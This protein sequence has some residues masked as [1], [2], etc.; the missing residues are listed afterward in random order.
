MHNRIL[1]AL[2]LLGTI[3]YG[4]TSGEYEKTGSGLNYKF[5][6]EGEGPAPAN[7]DVILLNISYLDENNNILFS[8]DD[9]QQGPMPLS[10]N[11]SVF[12]RTGGIEEGIKMIQE[13]DSLVL[14]FPIEDLYENT[15]NMTLPDSIRRGSNVTVCMGAADVLT[16]DEFRAYSQE[17]ILKMEDDQFAKDVQILDDYLSQE[18]IDAKVHESGLRYVIVEQGTGENAQNG[19]QVNVDYAGK[20]LNGALFDTSDE[21]LAKENGVY[22]QGRPYGPIDFQLGTRSVIPGWDIGFGLLNAGSKAV[23]YIP[24]KLAYGPRGSGPSIPPNS[25]LVF[26]VELVSIGN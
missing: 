9:T 14:Q 6:K 17:Q 11:D 7:G 26:D 12:V 18:N 2:A 3:L 19:Q 1:V 8:S 15:F 5:V 13:G 23:F 25:I 16:M 20:L 21:E 4:C 22:M 24:S 10:Y